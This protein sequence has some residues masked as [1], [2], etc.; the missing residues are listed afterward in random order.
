[1]S[2]GDGAAVKWRQRSC[3]PYRRLDA[4]AA[5]VANDLEV[6]INGWR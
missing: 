5:D 3:S 6:P 1:M 4:A 2:P